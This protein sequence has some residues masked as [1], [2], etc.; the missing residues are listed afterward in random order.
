MNVVLLNLL[1]M[2]ICLRPVHALDILPHDVPRQTQNR[3]NQ[4]LQPKDGR[5][6]QPRDQAVVLLRDTDHGGDGSVGRNEGEKQGHGARDGEH[7]VLGPVVGDESRLAE[8]RE[9][10]RA[11]HGRAP[12][13]VACNLAV[14]L[15]L[16]IGP[17]ELAKDVEH[18]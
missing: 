4:H 5:R 12:H 18:E 17:D 16:I 14:A 10:N 15:N 3:Q 11:V 1:D 7:V 2:V 9:Q 6:E 13:P 8:H